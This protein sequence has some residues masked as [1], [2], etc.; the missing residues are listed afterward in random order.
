MAPSSKTKPTAFLPNYPLAH[1]DPWPGLA[2]TPY[3]DVVEQVRGIRRGSTEQFA[4][5]AYRVHGRDLAPAEVT[6][7]IAYAF[8]EWAVAG[9]SAAP[10]IRHDLISARS[11]DWAVMW[12]TLARLTQR[13][14]RAPTMFDLYM[15]LPKAYLRKMVP[16]GQ[17]EHPAVRS[18]IRDFVQRFHVWVEQDPRGQATYER[19][20]N[21]KDKTGF[22]PATVSWDRIRVIIRPRTSLSPRSVLGM[23]RA[24]RAVWNDL[25]LTDSNPWVA[26]S[27]DAASLVRRTP[28][29]YER[30]A[31]AMHIQRLLKA[32]D[33]R[34]LDGARD[35]AV[36]AATV[37]WGLRASELVAVKRSDVLRMEDG[38]VRVRIAS[39]TKGSD[40]FLLVTTRMQRAIE[41]FSV[42]VEEREGRAVGPMAK[43]ATKVLQPD[44]PLFPSLFRWH[45]ESMHLEAKR[46]LLPNAV[47]K[48]LQIRD[49]EGAPR[50]TEIR[51]YVAKAMRLLK[52]SR[53]EVW[54]F[55]GSK[56]THNGRSADLEAVD[57]AIL[58]FEAWMSQ[59]AKLIW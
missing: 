58:S 8:A 55:L 2:G 40:R 10:D 1:D 11:P 3:A 6:P 45:R 47:Y 57:R 30:E 46:P 43:W 28:K 17:H 24:M 25:G 42:L 18:R 48:I 32:P 53:P 44:A 9:A 37:F 15:A 39:Q 50:P 4:A 36:I 31:T 41:R 19:W 54:Y 22:R 59:E 7:E 38:Q 27:K 5:W 49:I 12:E 26:L 23:V 16:S 56:R 29:V 34:T 14:G 13:L 51:D 21:A 33:T 35:F 52:T 20:R